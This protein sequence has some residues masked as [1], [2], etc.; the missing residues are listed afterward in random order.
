MDKVDKAKLKVLIKM[1]LIVNSP[2]VLTSNQLAN[3]INNFK[4]GFNTDITSTMISSLMRSELGKYNSHFL[5]GVS[6]HK[7]G[8]SV[9]YS[10]KS[11]N[12]MK[13]W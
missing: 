1:L 5:E 6:S 12:L 3:M 8:G 7:R 9:A 10:V 2:K 11:E 4:W 13:K